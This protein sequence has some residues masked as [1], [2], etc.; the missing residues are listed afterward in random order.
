MVSIYEVC[1]GSYLGVGI[2]GHGS[3]CANLVVFGWKGGC[4]GISE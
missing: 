4:Y 1:L 2:Y 3:I